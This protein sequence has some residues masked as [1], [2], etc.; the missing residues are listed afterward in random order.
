[1]RRQ[2]MYGVLVIEYLSSLIKCKKPNPGVRA[3]KATGKVATT[4]QKKTPSKNTIKN[5]KKRVFKVLRKKRSEDDVVKATEGILNVAAKAPLALTK[6]TNTKKHRVIKTN[7]LAANKAC[8]I[9]KIMIG[10]IPITLITAEPVRV[11][12]FRKEKKVSRKNTTRRIQPAKKD[13]TVSN[14]KSQA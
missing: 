10:S 8:T 3:N 9:T 12:S 1:M 13:N 14:I 11:V 5:A 6:V 4:V 2:D 7:T